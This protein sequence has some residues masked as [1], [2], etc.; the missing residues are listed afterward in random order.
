MNSA[1]R[2]RLIPIVLLNLILLV[3]LLFVLDHFKIFSWRAFFKAKTQSTEKPILEDPYL[4]E[5]E[6]LR[7]QWQVL[8][9]K[10]RLYQ[11][12][13]GELEKKE[14]VLEEK[15][16]EADNQISI[17]KE[18]Q[19][20]QE[21][22]KKQ[23]ED[24]RANVRNLASKIGNM[25][26]P[27]GV[28]LLEKMEPILAVDVLKEMDAIAIETQKKSITDY[29]LSLMDKDKASTIIRLIS[30]YPTSPKQD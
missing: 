1:Q 27:D 7:K 24:K 28:A 19:T 29:L 17:A 3:V 16:K 2:Q 4:L 13:T 11:E 20:K 15:L 6:E 25:P 26:P 18:M 5:K 14:Q 22:I 8:E 10:E 9:E 12:K 30:R 21:E 23:Y